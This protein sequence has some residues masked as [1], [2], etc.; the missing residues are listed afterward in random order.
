[1]DV[2]VERQGVFG[3]SGQSPVNQ[4]LCHAGALLQLI[5]LLRAQ[6]KQSRHSTMVHKGKVQ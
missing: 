1:M 5:A 2:Q 4:L 3:V 6:V